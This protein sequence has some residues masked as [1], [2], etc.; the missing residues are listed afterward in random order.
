MLAKVEEALLPFLLERFE[1]PLGRLRR[2][3]GIN[4]PEVGG[5]GLARP[6]AEYRDHEIPPS[7]YFPEGYHPKLLTTWPMTEPITIPMPESMQ[8]PKYK[9]KAKD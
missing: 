6:E 3:R 2:R 9:K 5:H 4:R 1:R 8:D 7:A